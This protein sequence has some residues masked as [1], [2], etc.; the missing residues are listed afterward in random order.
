MKKSSAVFS[1]SHKIFLRKRALLELLGLVVLVIFCYNQ[2]NVLGRT[3]EDLK[4]G[5]IKF[6][7]LAFMAYW[8]IPPLTALSYHFIISKNLSLSRLALTQLA[9]AG[10]G[11][12]IPGGLGGM[13]TFT[14]HLK[15]S[16]LNL[17]EAILSTATNNIFGV[18]ANSILIILAIVFDTEARETGLEILTR[19]VW[20]AVIALL[21]VI[22]LWQWLAHIHRIKKFMQKTKSSAKKILKHLGNDPTKVFMIL[23][24][25]SLNTLTHVTILILAGKAMG[26][27]ISITQALLAMSAG[28]FV[29]GVVPSPGGLG[30]VE[31]GI[32]G[33]LIVFGFEPAQATSTAIISRG[34]TYW[35]P[36]IPG[37]FSYLYLKKKSLL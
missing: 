7:V 20:T 33:S 18:I 35:Q 12:I 13:S 14:A 28:V 22:L 9:G 15:K 31:A 25:S 24:V 3:I 32:A 29:G 6:L 30:V 37:I 11:R 10:P 19:S 8:A 34:S 23:V 36:L 5:N 17:R 4:Q 1:A 16:G 21:A 26:L 27:D 2:R